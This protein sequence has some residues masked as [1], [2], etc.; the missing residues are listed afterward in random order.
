MLWKKDYELYVFGSWF[1]EKFA[2]NAKYLYLYFLHHGKNAVWITK[3]NDVYEQLKSLNL[4]VAMAYSREGRKYCRKAGFVF[5]CT[6]KNDLNENWIGGSTCID[7]Q[8]GVPLKK[9]M[10]DDTINGLLLTPKYKLHSFLTKL[11]LRKYYAASSSSTMSKIFKSALRINDSQILQFGLPRNDCFFDGTLSKVKYC[12]IPY[13]K[14]IAYMPTH[15]NT[16]S[17]PID[18]NKLF[19]LKKLNDFCVKNEILFVIKKHF[20]HNDESTNLNN[21]SNIID[22]TRQQCDSQELLFNADMLISDYSGIYIDYL[23]LNRPIIFYAY[24]YKKYLT[25]DRNL[26]F[27]YEEV[28][29]GYIVQD[30]ETL[31]EKLNDAVLKGFCVQ[32]KHYYVKDLFFDKNNQGQVSEKYLEFVTLLSLQ[33]SKKCSAS[34]K[35]A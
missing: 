26:Y 5:V 14:M 22:L 1:G 10:Y 33:K 2:D 12:D 4:P 18:I 11:P 23:L 8:H 32:D 31:F 7:L 20:Y 34:N 17:T 25:T 28:A 3:S 16:G 13:K 21:F 30:F 29:P 35:K 19:D 24:D 6:G 9:V 15:R 27:N